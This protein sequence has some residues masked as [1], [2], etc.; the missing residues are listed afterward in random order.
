MSHRF[1]PLILA[2]GF[3]C[4]ILAAVAQAPMDPM[5]AQQEKEA[6]ELF[7]QGEARMAIN[8]YEE[9]I[10]AFANLMKRYPDTD[11]RYKAQFRM[12]DAMVGL[13][14]EPKAL[15]LL[16]SVVKEENPDWSPRALVKIGDTYIVLQ[17]HADA[18]RAFKQIIADYPD[19]T[20]VDNAYFNIGKLHFLMGHF[21]LAAAA[22][23]KVGTA[24]ASQMPDLQRVSPGEPLYVRLTEP[25]LVATADSK[26][27]VNITT[28]S[29]DKETVT[30]YPEVEGGDRFTAALPTV[31]GTA[32][33][34]DNILELYGNDTVTLTYKSRYVGTGAVDRT[35][36]MA[37]ASNARLIIRD[38]EKNEVRGVVVKDTIII[39]VIDADRDTSNNADTIS[40]EIKTRKK[41]SE[42]LTLTETG[43]HTGIFQANIPTL[44][45]EPKPESGTIETNAEVAQGSTSQLDDAMTITYMDEVN[46]SSKDGGPRKV[47]AVVS[48]FTPTSGEVKTPSTTGTDEL[49]EIKAQLLKGRAT[50]QIASTYKDLGQTVKAT[51]SFK[52]AAEEFQKVITQYPSVPEVED[53][54]YGQYQNYVAQSNYTSAI[55]IINQITLRFPQS[56]RASEALMELA[57]LHVKTRNFKQALGI[58]QNLAQAARGTALAEEAQFSICTTY[59]EM[60]KPSSVDINS[61]G[62]EITP[63]TVAFSLEEFAR[64]YPN[65]ERTPDAL[66]QLVKFRYDLEDYRGAVD[67]ARR[68]E[69]MFPD[70]VVTGRVLL[71]QAQ[72]LVKLRL[73]DEAITV[74]KRIIANYGNEEAP[75]RQMLDTL[76]KK[77]KPTTPAK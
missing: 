48:M 50:T 12:A 10:S 31:L 52:K 19:S 32:K 3:C 63:E 4:A 57:S 43:P 6:E 76:M 64:A 17:K 30:I 71:L 69:A 56:S 26:L 40:A 65:S 54:L 55:A 27:I 58:Y 2:L 14:Q 42:K 73:F 72:A 25:N 77:V 21:E 35:I 61:R 70:S 59:I 37:T 23:D 51:Q 1:R 46:L 11:V 29:G 66:Y 18:F 60:L 15:E 5:R 20:I 22:L 38:S 34:G 41:D 13:K 36:T 7:T 74:L 53:A 9:A 45:E 24:A 44:Q 47:T 28:K 68:M 67:N 62:N 33:A 75:A 8:S 49:L 16:Q 39:E